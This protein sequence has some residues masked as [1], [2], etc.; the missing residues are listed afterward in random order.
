MPMAIRLCFEIM[1][2][3]SGWMTLTLAQLSEETNAIKL[4]I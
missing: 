2:I 1:K 3:F 4:Y